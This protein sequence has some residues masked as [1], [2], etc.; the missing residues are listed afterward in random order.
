MLRLLRGRYFRYERVIRVLILDGVQM[1]V[2]EVLP[3]SYPMVDQF[4]TD[5]LLGPSR[6]PNEA[7]NILDALTN[8]LVH[9]RTGTDVYGIHQCQ[10]GT[11]RKSTVEIVPLHP[12]AQKPG[13]G[14][15]GPSE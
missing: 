9:L 4:A 13:K 5:I 10:C 6:V 1:L 3:G 15:P 14:C 11:V 7:M 12:T 8:E 2:S